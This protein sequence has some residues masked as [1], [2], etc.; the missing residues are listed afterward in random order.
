LLILESLYANGEMV[1]ERGGFQT[2]NTQQ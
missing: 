1:H 2:T